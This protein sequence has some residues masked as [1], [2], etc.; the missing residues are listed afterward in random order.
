MIFWK[1]KESPE[2]RG[3]EYPCKA[4]R[5]VID[6]SLTHFGIYSQF[7]CK[8]T[9]K[10]ESSHSTLYEICINGRWCWGSQHIYYDGPHCSFSIGFIHFNWGGSPWTNWCKKCMP[11]SF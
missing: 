2:T 9:D 8:S 5:W 11:D 6:A 1:F 3:D 4:F 7:Q 10:W